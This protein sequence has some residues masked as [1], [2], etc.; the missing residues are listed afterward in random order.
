M[1]YLPR[2]ATRLIKESGKGPS[3]SNP[4]LV[5]KISWT[6]ISQENE[7]IIINEAH[8]KAKGNRHVSEYLPTV[9]CSD[10]IE[11]RNTGRFRTHLGLSGP[12]KLR[13]IV[14]QRLGD[15]FR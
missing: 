6:E 9:I 5:A 7:A 3:D 13:I 4:R 15:I 12:R 10:D 8:D 11:G 2:N 14:F 1:R